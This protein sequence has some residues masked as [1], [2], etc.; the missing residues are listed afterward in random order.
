M[1]M[2]GNPI[3]GKLRCFYRVSSQWPCV[4]NVASLIVA[5]IDKVLW[6]VNTVLR[7]GC[8]GGE[9]WINSTKLLKL[10]QLY[11]LHCTVVLMAYIILGNQLIKKVF[12]MIILNNNKCS[13]HCTVSWVFL[14]ILKIRSISVITYKVFY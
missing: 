14:S 12:P 7:K 5:F 3:S 11:P 8:V 10:A 4:H 9:R 1:C 6:A 2:M 13:G